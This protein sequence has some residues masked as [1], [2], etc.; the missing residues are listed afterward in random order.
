MLVMHPIVISLT[1]FYPHKTVLM[2]Y[3]YYNPIKIQ[4]SSQLQCHETQEERGGAR[5]WAFDVQYESANVTTFGLHCV[6][7]PRRGLYQR[8]EHC[9]MLHKPEME[10]LWTYM[11][12]YVYIY[13]YIY[14]H[15]YFYISIYL[16]IYILDTH[17]HIYICTYTHIHMPVDVQYRFTDCLSLFSPLSLS[18][19]IPGVR[20]RTRFLLSL[21]YFMVMVGIVMLAVANQQLGRI[22]IFHDGNFMMV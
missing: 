4:W 11:Y 1:F 21:L 9:E 12:N 18:L 7:V 8:K 14:M 22:G 13:M 19:T 16:Y 3:S 10:M 15:I 2:W 20:K 6:L 17:T 5:L